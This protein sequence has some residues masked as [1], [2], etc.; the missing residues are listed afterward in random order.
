MSDEERVRA[1]DWDPETPTDTVNRFAED[2]PVRAL[3]LAIRDV[4][5]E[6]TPNTA[7]DISV[8]IITRLIEAGYAIMTI[9]D[10][11][12]R[13]LRLGAVYIVEDGPAN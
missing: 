5:E 10:D 9:D 3:F 13:A 4:N 1:M 7:A 6:L 2:G 11:M 12:L 8:F